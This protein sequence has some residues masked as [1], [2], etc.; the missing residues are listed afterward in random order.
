METEKVVAKIVRPESREPT[1]HAQMDHRN[2]LPVIQIIHKPLTALIL[3]VCETCNPQGL[4][5]SIQRGIELFEVSRFN[6]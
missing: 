6:L 2:I 3:P 4:V 5:E 1:V